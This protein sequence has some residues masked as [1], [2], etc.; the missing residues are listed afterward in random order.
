MPRT[1][2]HSRTWKRRENR[3]SHGDPGKEHNPADTLILVQG[4]PVGLPT[5]RNVR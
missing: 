5:Y 2:D 1:M 3:F 4:D